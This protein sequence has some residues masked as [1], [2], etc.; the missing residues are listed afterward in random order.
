M[1]KKYALFREMDSFSIHPTTVSGEDM[2]CHGLITIAAIDMRFEDY[3]PN[4]FDM[5]TPFWAKLPGID[6]YIVYDGKFVD[7]L[8]EANTRKAI[9]SNSNYKPCHRDWWKYAEALDQ[10]DKR[11]KEAYR[12]R[13]SFEKVDPAECPT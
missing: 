9:F 7:I 10:H 12:L 2:P 3:C 6:K 1:F 8:D 11:V 13:G 5:R 4:E